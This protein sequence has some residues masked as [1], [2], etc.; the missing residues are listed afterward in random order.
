M[1]NVEI[2][3]VSFSNFVRA[4]CM[5]LEEKGVPYTLTPSR[6]HTPEIDAIH[7]LG[8]IPCMRHGDFAL[9]ESKAIATYIDR[10]FPGPKLI[11]EEPKAAAQVEQWVSII[12]VTL[13]PTF[14]GCLRAYFFTASGE[15]DMA[16]MAAALPAAESSLKL[17]D[18]AVSKTGYLVGDSLTYADLDL[19][20][21]L[22][23]MNALPET[24]KAL[25]ALPALS[26]YY[27]RHS[28]RASFVKTA[29]PPVSEIMA[30]LKQI[31]AAQ[32]AQAAA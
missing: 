21:A 8:K 28:Q 32:A 13:I 25:K 14:Q 20:A 17:L 7:P 23:L 29:P 24:S 2:L 26:A 5:T 12:N 6:P 10:V 18:H 15:P 3:G 27:D 4:V 19:M 1:S 9:C 31:R 30:M 22:G 16:A 11:P